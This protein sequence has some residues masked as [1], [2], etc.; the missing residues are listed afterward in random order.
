MAKYS[1]LDFFLNKNTINNDIKLKTEIDS[2]AQSVKNIIL[3]DVGEKMFNPFF[4]GSIPNLLFESLDW[5][6]IILVQEQLKTVLK[7]YEPR[8]LIK[9]IN[10]QYTGETKLS[11]ELTFSLITE[12]TTLRNLTIEI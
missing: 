8:I 1:D 7:L 10:I 9:S 5:R 12:P 6:E 2:V 4:G 3:T 11:I